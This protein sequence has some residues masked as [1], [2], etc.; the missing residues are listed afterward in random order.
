MATR[1]RI[2]TTL[3]RLAVIAGL[4]LAAQ[5]VTATQA[6]AVTFWNG[7]TTAHPYSNPTWWPLSASGTAMACY[8]GN[9][10][11]CRNP[12]QHTV[13][14]MDIAAPSWSSLPV[15]A[16]GAGVVHIRSTG[17]HC[18]PDQ[19]RGNWLYVDHGN[20][21]RSEYGHLGRIYVHTGDF[22]TAHT[23]L[24]TVGQSG[25]SQCKSKPY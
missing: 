15:Y 25:Y 18:N 10:P 11:D 13:Y 9:G 23:K 20:G 6:Q 19:G 8:R 3:T 7:A 22:V 16:M 21:T 2:R 4:A 5:I 24:A 14:A 1:R 17:W 12:L